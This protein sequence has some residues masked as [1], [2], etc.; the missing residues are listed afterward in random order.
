MTVKSVMCKIV[1]SG[2]LLLGAAGLAQANNG[3]PV[4]VWTPGSYT[5]AEMD[6]RVNLYGTPHKKFASGRIELQHHAESR[7]EAEAQLQPRSGS[8]LEI[9]KINARMAQ[10]VGDVA[11]FETLMGKGFQLISVQGKPRD[12]LDMYLDSEDYEFANTGETFRIRSENGSLVAYINWKPKSARRF[13]DGVVYRIELGVGVELD[14]TT[15]LPTAR[16]TAFLK[17]RLLRDNTIREFL[18]EHPGRSLE[19]FL[20]P[21]IKIDQ[22]RTMYHLQRAGAKMGEVSVDHV[23]PTDVRK[24]VVGQ[25]FPSVEI[26]GDHLNLTP[27]AAQL[28]KLAGTTWVGPHKAA[29][30]RNEALVTSE[31][32][33]LVHHFTQVLSAR[34]DLIPRGES[35]Y[36]ASAR[37]FGYNTSK[38]VLE[39]SPFPR[40]AAH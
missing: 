33:A 13:D 10:D 36:A 16:G 2:W 28:A 21:A 20:I 31:D 23:T 17:N 3:V 15:R 7:L 34:H 39:K 19:S 5:Q 24:N 4:Q 35:K 12:V 18:D 40:K 22:V 6:E 25:A 1:M 26:E 32:V 14:H 38:P 11:G 37:Q 30:T 29:D 27:N 9:P 8:I